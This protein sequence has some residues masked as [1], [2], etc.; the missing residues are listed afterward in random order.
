MITSTSTPGGQCRSRAEGRHG[1]NPVTAPTMPDEAAGPAGRSRR[2]GGLAYLGRACRGR[3]GPRLY[4]IRVPMLWR[5][6]LATWSATSRT[7][8]QLWMM[9]HHIDAV[10]GVY[11]FGLHL[12]LA[13]FGDSATAMRLPSAIAMTVSAAAVALAGRRLGGAGAG[14]AADCSSPSSRASRATPR[15][16]G[17]TR[18][19]R[20]SPRS[21]HCCCCA[22]RSC[23]AG[24]AGRG[25]RSRS[26]P[27]GRRTWSRC[28]SLAGHAA[29]V[30]AAC[31]P[32][33]RAAAA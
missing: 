24:I 13:V 22:R 30:L 12:W 27:P 29:A 3:R 28:A 8:P 25:T 17:P 18:S 23:R 26:P 15:R 11:Y 14:L 31:W 33:T 9:V 19:R 5:D 16:P 32:R 10:L 1:M 6:E 7:V 2:R 4:Q 20:A 21:P